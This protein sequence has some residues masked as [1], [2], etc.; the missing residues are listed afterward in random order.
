[1]TDDDL[2]GVHIDYITFK[3]HTMSLFPV[4][5]L[6]VFRNGISYKRCVNRTT[7]HSSSN[8]LHLVGLGRFFEGRGHCGKFVS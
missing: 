4:A 6:L 2:M 5:F 3:G 7:K 8:G 1:M